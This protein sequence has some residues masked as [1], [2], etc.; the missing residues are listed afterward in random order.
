MRRKVAGEGWL[1]GLKEHI[2]SLLAH[3]KEPRQKLMPQGPV[4]NGNIRTPP[5]SAA[6]PTTHLLL[7]FFAI[8]TL[9]LVSASGASAAIAA[10]ARAPTT[11]ATAA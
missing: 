4:D 9:D 3:S 5:C 2:D 7:I 6:I 8:T 10:A 11:V 1:R